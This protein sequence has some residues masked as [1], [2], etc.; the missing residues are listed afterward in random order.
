MESLS[1]SITYY[2][3]GCVALLSA[4]INNAGQMRRPDTLLAEAEEYIGWLED[5][6]KE[7]EQGDEGKE[8]EQAVTPTGGS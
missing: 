5:E 6:G 7:D 8:D 1:T 4:A 2:V 3:S